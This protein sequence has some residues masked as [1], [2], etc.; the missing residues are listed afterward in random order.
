[1][2]RRKGSRSEVEK[3]RKMILKEKRAKR[4]VKIQ[5]TKVE[6]KER[7]EKLLREVMIKIGLKQE[8]DEEGI[9][10][11]MLL[12]SKTIRLVIS[13]KFARKHKFRR[14]KLERPIY[15]RN[16]NGILNYVGLIVD[17]IEVEIYSKRYKERTLID[18]TGVQKWGV[19]LGMP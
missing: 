7:K 15:V 9:V 12:D 18:I 17:I 2:Q 13:E 11:E 10:V 3:N 1:M 4:R 19:I 5:Q 14:T 6:R 16:V 8:K